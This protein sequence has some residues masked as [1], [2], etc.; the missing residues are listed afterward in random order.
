MSGGQKV[1]NKRRGGEAGKL[2]AIR[3]CVTDSSSFEAP[4]EEAEKW[5]RRLARS[6]RAGELV[7]GLSDGS[8]SDDEE[9][10]YCERDGTWR[11]GRY[12]GTIVFEGRTLVIEPR[13][14]RMRILEWL[15]E[16]QSVLVSETPGALERHENFVAALLGVIWGRVFAEAARHGLPALRREVKTTGVVLR[17]ALSIRDSVRLRATGSP[18]LVSV[19]RERT[20][21]HAVSDVIVAAYSVLRR[22]LRDQTLQWL[23]GRAAE[24]LPHLIA[25]AGA[26]PAV[27]TMAELSRIRYTPITAGFARFA[28]LSR[29]IATHQGLGASVAQDGATHG[30][31]LDMAELWELHVLH[32]LRSA[33]KPLIVRHGTHDSSAN[34]KLL[35]SEVDGKELGTLMPDALLCDGE[36]VRAILDAKYKQ[37]HGRPQREDLYQLAAYLG[38]F[39]APDG[40]AAGA[41]V[42]PQDPH[43]PEVA[44]I[45]A[46]SP[47]RLD[48]GKRFWFVALPLDT[49]AAR[50]RS[51]ELVAEMGL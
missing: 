6:I 39:A 22:A 49:G 42:Y 36:R 13:F 11:A 4:S 27:P 3:L 1:A 31:L 21:D 23:P 9:I 15:S 25:V 51:A 5:L 17:G 50:A 10:V 20:L 30:V 43:R 34:A 33:C 18:Q 38:R 37:I 44:K 35:R 16:I 46:A 29:Q 14:G 47:W 48:V 12:I 45:E 40:K 32:V 7:V 8:R 24:L 19:R 26:H 28:E 2:Q 41:L